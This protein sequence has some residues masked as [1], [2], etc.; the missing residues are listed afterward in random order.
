MP[1]A[2]QELRDR[3]L[4][5]F[6]PLALNAARDLTKNHVTLPYFDF[7]KIMSR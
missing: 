2:A 1:L 7:S 3:S 5:F 4:S 6:G